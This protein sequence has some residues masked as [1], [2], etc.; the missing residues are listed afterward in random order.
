MGNIIEKK[1]AYNPS[2]S[3]L[4]FLLNGPQTIEEVLSE[5]TIREAERRGIEAGRKSILEDIQKEVHENITR[6]I[7][8][9]Q[10]LVTKVKE[11]IQKEFP[12]VQMLDF[13]TFLLPFSDDLNLFVI[14]DGIDFEEEIK[15]GFI[16]SEIEKQFLIENN[17]YCEI[18]FARK[19]ESLD[20]SA[21]K[22]DYPFS[23][24]V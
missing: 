10:A 17:I 23:L 4:E 19:T 11:R 12:T 21:I 8:S 15:I 14:L 9:L 16:F 1:P 7:G 18:L 24:K 20:I 22:R 3:E 2:L 13:K 6:Y 5:A